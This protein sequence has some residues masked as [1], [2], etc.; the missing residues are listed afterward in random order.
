MM[1]LVYAV[2]ATGTIGLAWL[3]FPGAQTLP[4]LEHALG[5]GFAVTSSRGLSGH[6]SP[7]RCEDLVAGSKSFQTIICRRDGAK[8]RSGPARVLDG[9]A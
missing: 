1:P 7:P 8:N 4:R 6:A 5:H 9:A 3:A 2:V